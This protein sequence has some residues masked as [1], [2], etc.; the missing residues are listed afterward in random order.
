[1][2]TVRIS[3]FVIICLTAGGCY[4]DTQQELYGTS[5]QSTQC[6]DTAGVTYSLQSNTSK[7]VANIITVNCGACHSASTSNSGGGFVLDNYAALVAQANNGNL[8]GDINH[9]PGHNAMP[10]NGSKLDGCSI[11]RLQHWI[12]LGKPNN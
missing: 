11:A 3:F 6:T 2:N 1:M 8:M 9:S 10:L 7:S 5:G 4:Y 12:D